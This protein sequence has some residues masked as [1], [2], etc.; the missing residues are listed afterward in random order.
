MHDLLLILGII[1]FVIGGLWFL[2]VAFQQSILWGIASILIP[3]VPLIFLRFHWQAGK[4]PFLVQVAGFALILLGAFLGG[5][6][7]FQ[8]H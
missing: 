8:R 6:A 5:D 2:V 4:K 7:I 3:I 1:V